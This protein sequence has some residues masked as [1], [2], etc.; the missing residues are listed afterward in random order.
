LAKKANDDQRLRRYQLPR[1]RDNDPMP[2][3][4]SRRKVT[5]KR[6]TIQLITYPTIQGQP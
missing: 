1:L 2:P 6:P 4:L 5:L 3:R